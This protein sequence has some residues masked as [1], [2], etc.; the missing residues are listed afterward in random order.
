MHANIG[1]CLQCKESW[2][3]QLHEAQQANASLEV[4]ADAGKTDLEDALTDAA[5]LRTQG[6]SL[7][8]QLH[9]R[10]DE[11]ASVQK[12]LTEALLSHDITSQ[13]HNCAVS[14]A[15]L[16]L[17]KQGFGCGAGPWNCL[18]DRH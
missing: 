10:S 4:E 13:V 17:A 15:D 16:L 5:S 14:L 2:Q 1:A 3:Q 18:T 8:A 12:S 9:Q 6:Q 7:T 11:V